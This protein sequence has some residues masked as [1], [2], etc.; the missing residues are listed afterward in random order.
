MK[1]NYPDG[2]ADLFAA[3]LERIPVMLRPYGYM[4]QVTM[5]SWMFLSSFEKLRTKLQDNGA[6]ISMAHLDNMVMRIAFGTSATVWQKQGPSTCTGAYTWV[7]LAD[8]QDGKPNKFP[9]D[10][11][12][13]AL[14]SRDK[15][16][17]VGQ[18]TMA[19][20]PGSPIVYWLSEKM[21]TSFALNPSLSSIADLRQ[22]LATADNNRFLR[23]WWEVSFRRIA[24]ACTSRED[25]ARSGARWFPYNKGGDF[26]KWYGNQEF[27]VNWE[28]DGAEIRVFGTEDGGRPRSRPQNTDT[29]FSPSVSWSKISSGAPAFRYYPN[30]FIFD[31]AGTS[32][33]VES[34]DDHISLLSFSNSRLA[35]EQLS[36]IAP[37]LNFEVGQVSGLPI[38]QQL[39]DENLEFVSVLIDESREDWDSFELSWSFS[40]NPLVTDAKKQ[41]LE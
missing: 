31:V 29:Y 22:G 6:I 17:R 16:F 33:F 5:Q 20:L 37:T 11:E 27:V 15:F 4:A 41:V 38:V 3:F 19:V 8:I 25:A 26:R 30:G 7:T 1:E 21:R 2:K 35:F 34:L 32:M 23:E 39:L 13:N 24:F 12:R 10:N 28:N 9:P 18:D 36:A 40:S 14:A